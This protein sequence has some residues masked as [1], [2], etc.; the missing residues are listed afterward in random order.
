MADLRTTYL[1]LELVS[2]LVASSGPLTSDPAL[3]ERLEAAGVGAVVLPSL[4]E[5][6]VEHEAQ[7]LEGLYTSNSDSYVEASSF[8]PEVPGYETVIDAALS[9]VERTKRALEIPVI[10]SVNG[11]HP[12]GW[13]RYADLLVDAGA[14]A[15][16]L[17]L[18]SIAADPA[19]GS[20]EI[21]RQQVELVESVVARLGVPVAVKLS[22]FYTGLAAFV[23]SLERVGVAGVSLFN[24]FY[25]PDIDVDLLEVSSRIALSSPD[26]LRLPLRWVGILRDQ[27]SISIAATSGVESGGDVVKLI[28]AGADVAMSTSALLRH[29]PE[30]AATVLEG[31]RR[32]MDDHDYE[33]VA[34]MRGAMSHRSVPD[35]EAFERSNYIGAL[36]NYT[37][38][39]LAGDR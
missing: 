17:N 34:Q 5:E 8:F 35:P 25:Q 33:T 30:H 27:V 22:P 2:P 18:Y 7:Q 20:A 24:R 16:E 12:G 10:A 23:A 39:Y 21:E 31:L 19:V 14:D 6:H 13:I 38:R 1:G 4:F 3:S 15:V 36:R 9:L 28:L 32:W 26:E 37:S 11:T 29:G